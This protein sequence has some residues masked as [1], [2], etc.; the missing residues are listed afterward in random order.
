MLSAS[1]FVHKANLEWMRRSE[2]GGSF[3]T[4]TTFSGGGV[5][6]EASRR[7]SRLHHH[8]SLNL[9]I[10]ATSGC[11]SKS[12]SLAAKTVSNPEVE[13]KPTVLNAY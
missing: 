5:L 4:Y 6:T 8:R 7:N 10:L 9:S 13:P 3:G 1:C 11:A 2:G 12:E